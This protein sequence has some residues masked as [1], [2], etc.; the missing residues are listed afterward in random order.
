[1]KSQLRSSP[2]LVEQ[3]HDV[4]QDFVEN[5]STRQARGLDPFY[6]A[7]NNYPRAVIAIAIPLAISSTLWGAYMAYSDFQKELEVETR[8]CD[9]I[10]QTKI[11]PEFT[12]QVEKLIAKDP[13]A[14]VIYAHSG[15]ECT[16]TI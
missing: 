11:T 3:T 14:R 15:G 7:I 10:K 12:E 16:F 8:A 9:E 2:F 4:N 6:D 1:M 5:A 13:G